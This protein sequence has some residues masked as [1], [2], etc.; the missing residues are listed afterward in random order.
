MRIAMNVGGDVL[1]A[2]VPPIQLAA[3]AQ[4][5]E[6]AGFPAVW[7]THVARGTDTL[8]AIAVAGAQTRSV[9]LGIGVVPTYP[10]HPHALAQTAAT[11]Q[12]LC[13][14]RFTL[15]IGSS[16][17][18]VIETALG[19]E[20]ASPAAHMR[21]YLQ[22]LGPLLST[23]EV[24][25]SG[26]FYNVEA[27]FT[28][29]GSTTPSILVAALGP[30]M[31]EVAGTY[32]D[33]TVTWMTGARG[34]GE[35]IAPG[36]AKA[37]EAAGRPAPRI[38]VG[39][40]VAVCDDVDAGRAAALATFARYDTLD[41]YRAQY[42]REGSSGVVDQTIYGPE[43]TVLRRLAELRDAGATELWAVPFGAG[44]DPAAGIA[45]TVTFLASL[46]PEL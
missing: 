18:P 38:V 16:H 23:G 1:G 17:R 35:Q 43:E 44:P 10:R 6:E 33:G 5:A 4:A 25:H 37:A 22:V 41:N 42:D 40:P 11:V 3:D 34:I 14:G 13:S 21:E 31:V 39:V 12:S 46:A 20:Y 32:A 45:R 19:L 30:K 27:S 28:V 2:P 8:A 24:R 29:V 9:E 15:G 36:L 26:R 7:T